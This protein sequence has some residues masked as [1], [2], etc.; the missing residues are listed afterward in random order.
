MKTLR[1]PE[2]AGVSHPQSYGGN[3]PPPNAPLNNAANSTFSIF[4]EGRGADKFG[5]PEGTATVPDVY[6]R[7]TTCT[8]LARLTDNVR[9]APDKKA[10]NAAKALL[11]AFTPSAVFAP[12]R[13]A[14]PD[15]LASYT[16]LVVLDFDHLSER[17]R[18][19]DALRDEIATHPSC[20]LTFKSPSGDGVKAVFPL[21]TDGVNT[22]DGA[23]AI[24]F[25]ARAYE[26]VR[27]DCEARYGVP[28]DTSGSDVSRLCYLAFDPQAKYNPAAAPFAVPALDVF[29][30]P[31]ANEAE[32]PAPPRTAPAHATS[33]VRRGAGLSLPT[34]GADT[35]RTMADLTGLCKLVEETGT[36]ITSGYDAWY[37]IS[38]ALARAV[39]S[40][41]LPEPF[42]RMAFH[43]LSANYP[44]YSPVECERKFADA[45]GDVSARQA[46]GVTLGTVFHIAKK[47]GLT[48]RNYRANDGTVE[49]ANDGVKIRVQR[50]ANEALDKIAPGFLP[51]VVRLLQA[52]TNAGK[53]KTVFALARRLVDA[54]T[55][56]RVW[57]VGPFTRLAQ[58]NENEYKVPGVYGGVVGVDVQA[59]R[60]ADVLVTTFNGL[61]KLGPPPPG[62]LLVVDESHELT[63]AQG[64]RKNAVKLVTE[65]A[66]TALNSGG[67]LL[68]VTAT[69]G[70]GFADMIGASVLRIEPEHV[71]RKTVCVRTG[72]ARENFDRCIFAFAQRLRDD[73]GGL[74]ALFC[75]SKDWLDDA[76]RL[77]REIGL[78]SEAI[79]KV[80]A[81]DDGPAVRA[82]LTDNRFPAGVRGVLATKAL[83]AG[84]NVL[85]ENV[86]AVFY[87]ANGNEG[88]RPGDAAQFTAR[89]RTAD[90]LEVFAYVC[91]PK[92]DHT[93]AGKTTTDLL[94]GELWQANKAIEA[95]RGVDVTPV[96]DCLPALRLGDDDRA[97]KRTT[98]P[99]NGHVQQTDKYAAYFH[100]SER[101]ARV[102]SLEDFKRE[103][104][105][106]DPGVSFVEWDEPEPD[107]ET[108]ALLQRVRDERKEAQKQARNTVSGWEVLHG[109]TVAYHAIPRLRNQLRKFDPR[110]W[111]SE[112]PS[113]DDLAAFKAADGAKAAKRFLGHQSDGYDP[114]TLWRLCVLES[115]PN[116]W[117][118][119]LNGAALGLH[120]EREAGKIGARDFVDGYKAFGFSVWKRYGLTELVRL[121]KTNRDGVNMKEAYESVRAV[122]KRRGV[123]LTWN[124]F[125]SVL[126]PLHCHIGKQRRISDGGGKRVRVRTLTIRPQSDVS[127]TLAERYGLD[128]GKLVQRKKEQRERG[129]KE[130]ADKN[131]AIL[132]ANAASEAKEAQPFPRAIIAARLGADNSTNAVTFANDPPDDEPCPY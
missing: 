132:R 60:A 42:A 49:D 43:A 122:L 51:G 130:A 61:A 10:R 116:K 84:Y 50:Y 89:F 55:F 20:L 114:Q 41:V 124:V 1:T 76:E 85:N 111:K 104:Q 75:N 129:A 2:G 65:A 78:P 77:L 66:E 57:I 19:A 101:R 8:R 33:A 98:D 128:W 13:K 12:R 95:R 96:D 91:E 17:G 113:D 39:R 40:D 26:A 108:R 59:A 103:W 29:A 56:R 100:A 120:L 83:G 4:S 87:C 62:T 67:A 9:N 71:N 44:Q 119:F 38:L 7:I 63:D 27:A 23:D 126:V 6:E 125:R 46:G 118:A 36:D 64:Y 21:D 16:G 121:V 47:H 32:R 131:A 24:G 117:Q 5:V 52:P 30:A 3:V 31:P 25:H 22:S 72:T 102:R 68:Y 105:G 58:Q 107:G 81:T 127:R 97:V 73:P 37:R 99:D 86:R 106:Y 69:P 15:H 110:V 93:D 18:Q 112:R 74:Y 109:V 14:L 54:G 45:L 79:A 34:G 94:R 35:N 53:T 48:L 90:N 115:N 11:P 92:S 123:V 70:D 28:L 88:L 80:T 82:L